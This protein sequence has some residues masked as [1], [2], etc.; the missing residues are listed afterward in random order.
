MAPSSTSDW[1]FLSIAQIW[2]AY[3][4]TEHIGNLFIDAIVVAQSN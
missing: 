3:H 2:N 1:F 4:Y